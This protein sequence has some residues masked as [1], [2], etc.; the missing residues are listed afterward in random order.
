MNLHEFVSTKRK[1]TILFPNTNNILHENKNTT[2]MTL[3]KKEELRRKRRNLSESENRNV[4]KDIIQALVEETSTWL[5]TLENIEMIK[6][7]IKSVKA[8]SKFKLAFQNAGKK[9]RLCSILEIFQ[10]IRISF[11]Q[12]LIFQAGTTKPSICPDPP[13]EVESTCASL[14]ENITLY[15]KRNNVFFSPQ[16]WIYGVQLQKDMNH[17]INSFPKDMGVLLLEKTPEIRIIQWNESFQKLCPSTLSLQNSAIQNILRFKEPKRGLDFIHKAEYLF[18]CPDDS[19]FEEK[20]G[21]GFLKDEAIFISSNLRKEICCEYQLIRIRKSIASSTAV[22][23]KE[24]NPNHR[25]LVPFVSYCCILCLFFFPSLSSETEK[26][27]SMLQS[28]NFNFYDG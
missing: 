22:V 17:L 25:P 16:P 9:N 6:N 11:F 4:L 26:E 13:R 12:A 14:H 8:L 15:K 20:K 28:L 7:D 18:S 10:W 19:T 24:K 23:D 21:K 2:D 3:E 27:K 5:D 1:L